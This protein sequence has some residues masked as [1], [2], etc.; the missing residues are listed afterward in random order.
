M[1]KY[2]YEHILKGNFMN[3]IIEVKDLQWPFDDVIIPKPY[4]QVYI[5]KQKSRRIDVD[6]F[7]CYTHDK[8]QVINIVK[9]IESKFPIEFKTRYFI[10]YHELLCRVNGMT[11]QEWDYQSK[12]EAPYD[13]IPYILLSGKRVPIH[14]AVTRYLVP[15]EYGHVIEDWILHK[16]GITVGK[17]EEIEFKKESIQVI[18][19]L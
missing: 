19:M 15:H 10:L 4:A 11:H 8:K 16:E 3:R 9:D 6:P 14:P 1:S 17:Q 7:P 5:T 12:D 13:F 18:A 2:N